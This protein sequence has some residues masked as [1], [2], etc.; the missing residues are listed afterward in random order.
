MLRGNR[1][2]AAFPHVHSGGGVGG[3]G[4]AG[5]AARL[6]G[7]HAAHAPHTSRN[8]R[9]HTLLPRS[10]TQKP[11][12]ARPPSFS[13]RTKPHQGT[14]QGEKAASAFARLSKPKSSSVARGRAGTD[15]PTSPVPMSDSPQ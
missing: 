11:T 3:G 1:T 13:S 8:N 15:T 7:A 12:A 2:H 5:V 6:G 4:A 14:H 10:K 9:T